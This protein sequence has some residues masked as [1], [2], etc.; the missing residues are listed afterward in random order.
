MGDLGLI[1]AIIGGVLLV[2]GALL[3]WYS[4]QKIRT[5]FARLQEAQDKWKDAKRA[6]EN[7]RREAFLKL[8]DEI[9]HKRKEFDLELKRERLELDRLQSKLNAKYETIEKRELQFDEQRRELQ[10]KERNISRL[11]DTVRANESRLKS[12]Y[13]DLISKL[14]QVANMTKEEAKQALADTLESE[15]RL[16]SQKWIQKVEEETRQTA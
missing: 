8:K 16:A 10:Q 6:I 2:S 11:E 14:E 5:S 7:E 15:V 12:L 1:L 3:F 9:F 13:T 4:Y